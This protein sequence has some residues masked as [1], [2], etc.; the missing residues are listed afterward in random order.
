M[1]E[2]K[3]LSFTLVRQY[4]NNI[5]VTVSSSGKLSLYTPKQCPHKTIEKFLNKNWNFITTARQNAI[6][7]SDQAIFGNDAS[8]SSLLYL[9]TRYPI[10]FSNERRPC[11]DGESFILPPELSS[12][13]YRV[14]ITKLYHSLA[15]SYISPLVKQ[16]SKERRLFYN[17]VKFTSA[18]S[19]WGSCTSEKNLNF[20]NYLICVPPEL[21]RY[22]I[23][24]ELTH[25]TEMNHSAAFYKKLSYFEP[26]HRALS[27]RLKTEYGMIPH[28][29]KNTA[30]S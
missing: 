21:I 9:G 5:R 7:N 30:I 10:I 1:L 16:L 29:F 14:V 15:Q 13:E 3:G 20:S 27:Q 25:L 11:F 28:I 24:H 8:S 26:D 6:S 12:N 19:R 17:D 22:V 2:F 23:H 18:H 4:R